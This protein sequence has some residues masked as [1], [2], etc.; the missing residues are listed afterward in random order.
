MEVKLKPISVLIW[1]TLAT[2][3]LLLLPEGTGASKMQP[4]FMSH[5]GRF[6]LNANTDCRRPRFN[7]CQGCNVDIRMR[8]RQNSACALNLQSLGPFA[9]QEVLV[10]PKNGIYGSANATATSYRPNPG[11]LGQAPF[12]TPLYFTEGNGKQTL[13]NLKA[14]TFLRTN[15]RDS[16]VSTAPAPS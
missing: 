5:K 1:S 15:L 3:V 12:Q 7:L 14:N 6:G 13:L 4:G 2:A 8:V 16:N 11:Y 10:R 9:G